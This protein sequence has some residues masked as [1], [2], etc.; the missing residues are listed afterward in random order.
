MYGITSLD[1]Q[2][3]YEMW[4]IRQPARDLRE[5]LADPEIDAESAAF[6]RNW[7]SPA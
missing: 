6:I 3:D 7:L 1:G 4:L 5:M 2:R